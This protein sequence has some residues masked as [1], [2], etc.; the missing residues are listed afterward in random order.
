MI[1]HTYVYRCQLRSTSTTDYWP[2][3]MQSNPRNLYPNHQI[4]FLQNTQLHSAQQ[5][6]RLKPNLSKQQTDLSLLAR[7]LHPL[8]SANTT[9][10]KPAL[11]TAQTQSTWSVFQK[12]HVCSVYIKQIWCLDHSQACLRRCV[13]TQALTGWSSPISQRVTRGQSEGDE[14]S[15]D[16]H[17][18]NY[19][20]V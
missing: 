15:T 17:F 13:S 1:L 12:W 18:P 5:W 20:F 10:L 4:I 8:R 19:K 9:F 14:R 2:M 3:A 16:L 6:R 7:R 11:Q